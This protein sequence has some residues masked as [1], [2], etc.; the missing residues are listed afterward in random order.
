MDKDLLANKIWELEQVKKELQSRVYL[1]DLFAFNKEVLRAEEGTNMVPLAPFHKELCD[2]ITGG[3]KKNKLVLVPRSHLKSTLITIGYSLQ[4]IAENPDVRIL[5]ANATYDMA[6]SFLS[7]IKKHLQNNETFRD[8][9]GDLS[10]NAD[11]W[12][13]NMITIQKRSSYA[14]KE[15]TVTAY[16]M[17]GNLVSQHYDLIIADDLV[18][19]DFIS[20]Q[21]QIQ[22]T[23]MFY[24]DALDLLE[25]GGK[26]IVIGTRWADGDLYGWMMDPSTPEQ[27]YKQFDI[28]IKKAYTGDL[29]TGKDLE[30]LY[31]QK[32]TQQI[33]KTLRTNKGFTEFSS[34]YMNEP[35]PQED[36][37]FKLDW[38]KQVLEDELRVRELNYFTMV[39][40][41]IGQKKDSD[42]TAIVTIAVDQWN[43]W[44][45]VNIIWD[46][47]LPNQIIDHVFANWEHYHPRR[48]GVEMTAYQKSLQYAL[49]D[50]MRRR[51]I[52][53][54][55]VE[56][57]A[58][59]SKQERIEG[60]IPRYANGTIFHLT[61]CPFREAMEEQFARYPVGKH[62]DI[63]D[64]LAYGL[65]IAHQSRNPVRN[66]DHWGEK[67]D[68]K[69]HYIY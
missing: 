41:A 64:A 37:K 25:P 43:N 53:L 30:L 67:E 69:K 31:P 17:G 27:V 6:T 62:D 57:K 44:F 23:I 50:E 52:F 20:T 51:N 3:E 59:R 8:Y 14:K 35:L 11:K 26:F 49:V 19:R 45:V 29:E 9:Y 60:L 40:P 22:K 66:T 24:K 38:F 42:K 47:L 4:R 7:Q 39:D 10:T 68:R 65:Q 54:P 32:Y 1:K 56:L 15:A 33:L 46:R 18:N 63:I 34:Q 12:S 55:I 28:M 21:E 61:Q 2:F 5:I 13:E 48:I 36:A 58:E 16:G